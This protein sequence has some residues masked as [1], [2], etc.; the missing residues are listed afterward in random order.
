MDGIVPAVRFDDRTD[1]G[2]RLGRRLATMGLHDV[3]VLGIPRGGVPVAAQ[4]ASLLHAPLDVIIVRKLGMPSQPEVAMGAIAEGDVRIVDVPLVKSIHITD[5][6][7]SRVE[8]AERRTLHRR[9]EQLRADRMPSRIA[10][11]TALI[12]DDGI[13]TGST[14]AA[15]CAAARRLGAARVVVAAPVAGPRAL[16]RLTGA[17]SVV[18]LAV[19][20]D[21]EA[22]GSYYRSFEATTDAEVARLLAA[23]RR[24]EPADGAVL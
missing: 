18:A 12:V 5:R 24:D 17:D 10:G 1:A 9:A 6:E 2:R 15:A 14:A 7:F 3:I 22:V 16:E 8:L 13:A 21:F 23:A 4:V 20:D 11:R 19:P